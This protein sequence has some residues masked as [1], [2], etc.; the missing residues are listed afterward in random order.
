M[1]VAARCRQLAMTSPN[2]RTATPAARRCAATESPYGPAPTTTTTPRE[3]GF[4]ARAASI[5]AI[6]G[7]ITVPGS[8]R[9]A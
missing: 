7:I 5:P 8:Q 9:Y 1:P 6:D 4:F 2:T 3:P